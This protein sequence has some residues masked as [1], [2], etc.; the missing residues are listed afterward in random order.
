MSPLEPLSP[1]SCLCLYK[2]LI[3]MERGINLIYHKMHLFISC[4]SQVY[5]R[6]WSHGI[7]LPLPEG[8][9]H[10]PEDH[11]SSRLCSSVPEGC[12]PGD[13]SAANPS[14]PLCS[15]LC[16]GNTPILQA[17]Y[18]HCPC[19]LFKSRD[20]QVCYSV[21]V[22]GEHAL[23]FCFFL[24]NFGTCGMQDLSSQTRD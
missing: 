9:C 17:G 4:C 13:P 8:F 18:T 19:Q 20:G 5:W 1:G 24:L 10:H 3:S 21:V 22:A 2:Y 6:L 14:L 11:S 12:L 15:T 7:P 23:E 16:P